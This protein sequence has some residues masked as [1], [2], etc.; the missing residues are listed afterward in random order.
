MRTARNETAG[1]HCGSRACRVPGSLGSEPVLM[2][3]GTG[4]A[5]LLWEQHAKKKVPLKMPFLPRPRAFIRAAAAPTGFHQRRSP[6]LLGEGTGPLSSRTAPGDDL[7]PI[8][9]HS[10]DHML[11]ATTVLSLARSNR[12]TA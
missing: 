9:A 8:Q 3:D 2:E 1:E 11:A 4:Y 5:L 10:H 12:A 6:E 7:P